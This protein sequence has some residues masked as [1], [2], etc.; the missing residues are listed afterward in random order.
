M[1]MPPIVPTL[2]EPCINPYLPRASAEGEREGLNARIE[3]LD[4]EVAVGDGTRLADQLIQP[5]LGHRAAALGVDV[6][7]VRLARR[8]PVE[9]HAKAHGGASR[10]RS[11]DEVQIARMKAIRDPAVGLVQHGWLLLHGP[12][13]HQRP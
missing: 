2:N 3:E 8:S 12:V 13:T 7:A 9:P 11:Q 1:A 4:L 6:A 5:L 10:G